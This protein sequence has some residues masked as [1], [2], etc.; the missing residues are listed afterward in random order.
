MNTL[1][2]DIPSYI[3][4]NDKLAEWIQDNSELFWSAMDLDVSQHDDRATID[5]VTITEVK[6]DEKTV[7]IHYEYEYSAYYGCRDMNYSDTAEE[8][9]IFGQRQGSNKLLFEKFT[10]IER[11]STNEEF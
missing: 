6:I 9:V 1:L 2:I 3:D 8:N 7:V 10:P 5:D 11:R 4:G